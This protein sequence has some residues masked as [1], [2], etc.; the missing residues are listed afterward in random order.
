MLA[1]IWKQ[2]SSTADGYWITD[3][4]RAVHQAHRLRTSSTTVPQAVELLVQAAYWSLA[5][6]EPGEGLRLSS[7]A[8]EWSRPGSETEDAHPERIQ[9]RVAAL[10]CMAAAMNLHGK[11]GDAL[12]R[13]REAASL[14]A[15]LAER[16]PGRFTGLAADVLLDLARDVGTAG[17]VIEAIGILR[18]SMSLRERVASGDPSAR[19]ASA[20]LLTFLLDA[21][22]DLHGAEKA[23]RAALDFLSDATA[24]KQA[25]AGHFAMALYQRGSAL[26]KTGRPEE[27]VEVLA[28]AVK[29]I[30]TVEDEDFEA[31]MPRLQALCRALMAQTLFGMGRMEE[32]SQAQ[33][34][35][36][37]LDREVA[38]W[39]AS[40]HGDELAYQLVV[41]GAMLGKVGR[42][43]EARERCMEALSLVDPNPADRFPGDHVQPAHFLGI[44]ADIERRLGL[45][46]A[47]LARLRAA[48]QC[49]RHAGQREDA[50]R[51]IMESMAKDY[52]LLLSQLG[53]EPDF[54]GPEAFLKPESSPKNHA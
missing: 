24:R 19:S 14:A 17:G 8:E 40:R 43:Q 34:D 49:L 39:N 28:E 48:L 9:A 20:I 47:A 45:Q 4:L 53:R 25:P 27:A 37:A 36:V 46:G 51:L 33:A 2:A 10:R 42:L 44:L 13:L 1:G 6:G 23:S 29:V 30:E 12:P 54:Q 7:M 32:A 26:A 41:L 5:H 3:P 11:S 50:D 15:G 18:A 38:S 52:L 21:A 35:A 22:N 16:E 31:G